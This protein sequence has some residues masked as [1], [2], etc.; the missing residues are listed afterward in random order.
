MYVVIFVKGYL[1]VV[2]L[3]LACGGRRYVWIPDESFPIE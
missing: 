1:K 3:P 2:L